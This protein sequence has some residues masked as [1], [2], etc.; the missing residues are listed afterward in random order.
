MITCIFENNH[1]A[2]LRH[3]TMG[4]IIVDNNKILLVKRAAHLTNPN[5]YCLP[6]G[7]LSHNENIVQGLLRE[8]QEETGYQAEIISLFRIND[9]PDRKGEDRQNVDFVFL[10]KPIKKVSEPDS[11]VQEARWFKLDNLPPAEEFAFDHYEN[12]ELYISYLKKEFPLPITDLDYK[13]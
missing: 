2:S 7:F 6:G 10:A 3:V 4:A 1:Q 12:I 11:E 8:V 9:R 5:K 13:K